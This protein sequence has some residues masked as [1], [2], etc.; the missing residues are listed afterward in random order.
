MELSPMAVHVHFDAHTIGACT[1]AV[2]GTLLAQSVV[3]N[4]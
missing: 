4:T 1:T 2:I 3:L